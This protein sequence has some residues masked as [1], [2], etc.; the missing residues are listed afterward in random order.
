MAKWNMS[1]PA[2]H[3]VASFGRPDA[4]TNAAAFNAE[5]AERGRMKREAAER[6]E[7]EVLD[8]ITGLAKG[9][10]KMPVR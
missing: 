2:S 5:M 10:T 9:Y 1:L 8:G 7:A 4:T 3:R 6:R